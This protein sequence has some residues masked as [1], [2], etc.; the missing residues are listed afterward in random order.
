V[1]SVKTLLV[2]VAFLLL[3]RSR[4]YAGRTRVSDGLKADRS[5]TTHVDLKASVR[6]LRR[7]FLS[8]FAL[9]ASIGRPVTSSDDGLTL[10]LL[11]VESI[12]ADMR[13]LVD[14]ERVASSDAAVTASGSG[15]GF[16]TAGEGSATSRGAGAGD[17]ATSADATTGAGLVLVM[18]AKAGPRGVSGGDVA[19]PS[20]AL[21]VVSRSAG[22]G[23]LVFGGVA[24]R[25]MSCDG[26]GVGS[27]V[28]A[29]EEAPE[30]SSRGGDADDAIS[31]SCCI[32]ASE[33]AGMVMG[34]E[35]SAGGVVAGEATVWNVVTAGAGRTAPEMGSEAE[36]C[37]VVRDR[38]E[39][40][41]ERLES[42]RSIDWDADGGE[43]SRS[44]LGSDAYSTW[45][46]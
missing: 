14:R 39:L 8:V 20:E 42:A 34:G 38:L 12:R 44:G 40:G 25:A 9:A 18:S 30:L 37:D 17:G 15:R 43:G 7:P 24:G 46:V 10:W 11:R 22:V 5:Q 33:T 31:T 45:M 6:V 28:S 3:R 29:T 1:G 16:S 36:S 13:E 32:S 19:W 26:A 4:L 2:G 35:M 27:A 21:G 23:P 41:R